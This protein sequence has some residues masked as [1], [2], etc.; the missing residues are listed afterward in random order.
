MI[1][2]D[3]KIFYAS[4]IITDDKLKFINEDI[5]EAYKKDL[6]DDLYRELV[7]GLRDNNFVEENEEKLDGYT[8]LTLK[9]VAIKETEE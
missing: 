3:Q 5:K 6:V 8:K 4:S 2:Y 1:R 7:K 9:L